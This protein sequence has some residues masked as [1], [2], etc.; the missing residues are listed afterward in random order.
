MQKIVL[1]SNNKGKIR[2][3]G[4]MLSTLKLEVIPQAALKIED[5]DETG[6]S[7]VEN[8][9]L[10]ARH[11]SAIAGLPAIA[12]DKA[13]I[14]VETSHLV[15][16]GF[17]EPLLKLGVLPDLIIHRRAARDIALSM[18]KMGTIPGK[19]EK[20][21]RFYLSPD[22]PG[23]LEIDNW[24]ELEDYQICFW[25]CLEIERRARDYITIFKEQGARVVETTLA[26]LKTF[27]GLETC[28]SGLDLQFK[29]PSF[30][31]RLRF[32]RSAGVKVNESKE[33][34]KDVLIPENLAELE[35]EVFDRITKQDVKNWLVETEAISNG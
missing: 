20:G 4:E 19:S 16:K 29:Y 27:S 11:A 34:K 15:C 9:I 33:T 6:L 28:F 31:T 2:E 3:F 18:L 13:P 1:A 25:Y 12:D 30:L 22:D 8:A 32:N 17:L 10:K 5:A 14:Y 23:V 26:G 35:S 24:R 7:F 21:L